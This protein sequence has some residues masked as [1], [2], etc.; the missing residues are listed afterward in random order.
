[1]AIERTYYSVLRAGL[2]VAATGTIIVRI[3]GEEW[4]EWLSFIL[5]GVFVA[6]GY[7]MIIVMLR[8][9]QKVVNNLKIEHGLDVMS[10]RLTI[11]LATIL[12]VTLAIVLG[13]FLLSLFDIP[14]PGAE[15]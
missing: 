2:V 4:P 13:M 8:R 3:L 10:P 14:G 11:D 12:Q 6:V 7:T 9:Y 1:M 15:Q 5:F